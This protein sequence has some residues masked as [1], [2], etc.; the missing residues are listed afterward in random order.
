MKTIAA[1]K[2]K[3]H[4]LSLLDD[5]TPDGLTVTK[6]GKP[7]AVIYPIH[8]RPAELIGCMKGRMKIE[9]DIFSTGMKWDAES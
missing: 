5:L 7:V 4:C 1:A 2:F 8:K 6:H 9:G 3:E